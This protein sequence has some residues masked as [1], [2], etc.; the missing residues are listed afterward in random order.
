M[1]YTFHVK[2]MK[3]KTLSVPEAD[4][5]LTKFLEYPGK[6]TLRCYDGDKKRLRW[7]ITATP[8]DLQA[9][10]VDWIGG[11]VNCDP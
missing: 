6:A 1:Q 8:S 4:N 9:F 2:N 7:E 5:L 3:S 11:D 10:F